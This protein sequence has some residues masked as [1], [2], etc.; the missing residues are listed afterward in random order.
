MKF[1]KKK[2]NFVDAKL[3]AG[4]CESVVIIAKGQGMDTMQFLGDHRDSLM[5]FNHITCLVE[6]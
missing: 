1:L 2:K 5:G 4:E 6:D 3:F